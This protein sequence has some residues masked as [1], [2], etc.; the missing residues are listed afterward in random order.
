MFKGT[1]FW[2]FLYQV[3]I[4]VYTYCSTHIDSKLVCYGHHSLHSS[5]FKYSLKV[6]NTIMIV[7]SNVL[8][9]NVF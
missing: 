2:S 9:T 8:F 6:G 3:V 5:T 1:I 7:V 4:I